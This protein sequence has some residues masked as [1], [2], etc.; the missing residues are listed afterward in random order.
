MVG[1]GSMVWGGGTVG[2]G[3]VIRIG[4]G[5]VGRGVNAVVGAGGFAG[6]SAGQAGGAVATAVG[7][8]SVVKA[9]AALQALRVL[10]LMALTF[11]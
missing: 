2:A 5:G 8:D 1:A 6:G 4:A 9:P 3:G 10:A 11:Q 7:G